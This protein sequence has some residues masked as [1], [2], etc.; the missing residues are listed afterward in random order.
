MVLNLIQQLGSAMVYPDCTNVETN[1]KLWDL[2]A[3]EWDPQV[4]WVQQMASHLPS[5]VIATRNMAQSCNVSE[6]EVVGAVKGSV[7]AVAGESQR[8]LG[9]AAP[10]FAIAEQRLG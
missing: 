8:F 6:C 5:E 9:S 7:A 1:R 2:Y 4:Q 3:Q 10:C